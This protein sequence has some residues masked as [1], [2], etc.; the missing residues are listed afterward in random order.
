MFVRIGKFFGLSM[1]IF[2]FYYAQI[3]P[4]CH[5]LWS[6][7]YWDT[8]NNRYMFFLY[9]LPILIELLSFIAVLFLS[10]SEFKKHEKHF[11]K[12]KNYLKWFLQWILLL[13]SI[14]IAY[15]LQLLIRW[16]VFFEDKKLAF[17]LKVDN[18]FLWKDNKFINAF[19]MDLFA[20]I[21][22][23]L[24]MILVLLCVHWLQRLIKAKEGLKDLAIFILTF[25]FIQVYLCLSYILK[26]YFY[27]WVSIL[28][29][30]IVFSAYFLI[31]LEQKPKQKKEELEEFEIEETD[32]FPEAETTDESIKTEDLQLPEDKEM[33][34]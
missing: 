5:Y 13:F 28:F 27:D 14:S 25:F 34:D 19:Q 11:T 17:S 9:L 30:F 16:V 2:L 8:I 24:L 4:L 15:I 26:L 21:S 33:E 18:N 12:I 6:T 31:M 23:F 7:K 22:L 3:K 1:F 10:L 20:Q 29:L 32:S